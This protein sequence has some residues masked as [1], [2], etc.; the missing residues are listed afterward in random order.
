GLL[1]ERR[2]PTGGF[3]GSSVA[4][5]LRQTELD[6][7]ALLVREAM[8]NSVDARDDG[9]DE[10][11][12]DMHLRTL[13]AAQSNVLRGRVLRAALDSSALKEMLKLALPVESEGIQVLEVADWG[14]RGLG[15][16]VDPARATRLGERHDFVD[17]VFQIG[18]TRDRRARVGGGTFGFGKAAAFMMSAAST[19]LVHSAIR[20]RRGVE[21]RFIGIILGAE[22]SH[23]RQMYSGRHWLGKC[24]GGSRSIQP[25]VGSDARKVAEALG[26]PDRRKSP[27]TTLCIVAPRLDSVA[28]DSATDPGHGIDTTAR[29]V[30]ACR[31]ALAYYCWPLMIGVPGAPHPRVKARY[32]VDSDE[33]PG[34]FP[35]G[36]RF[37][38]S[39]R[40]QYEAL[41]GGSASKSVELESVSVQVNPGATELLGLH[42]AAA[43]RSTVDLVTGQLAL[44]K[45]LGDLPAF[46]TG[47]EHGPL[48]AEWPTHVA[49]MR[50][51]GTVVRYLPVVTSV[52]SSPSNALIGSFLVDAH[53]VAGQVFADAEPP[54]HDDWVP[55]NT[56]TK[57][58]A[59]VV[60]NTLRKVREAAMNRVR[61]PIVPPT[62]GDYLAGASVIGNSLGRVVALAPGGRPGGGG[63]S[64]GGAGSGG[65]G[66][67]GAKVTFT[68]LEVRDGCKIARFAV[69]GL[70]PRHSWVA[71]VA[72]VIDR[73]KAV[74]ELGGIPG[75]PVVSRWIDRDG[76]VLAT[77]ST[78]PPNAGRSSIDEECFVEVMFDADYAIRMSVAR[79]ELG[80]GGHP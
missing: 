35:S 12:F 16:P 75:A 69:R 1:S 23:R 47:R 77:G 14:T 74:T 33:V 55:E 21:E 27:G 67:E 58:G 45:Y 65:G 42:P 28:Q 7:P 30:A 3:S 19:V 8:Q 4:K 80:G 79:S 54:A 25:L 52:E 11:G 24:V 38:Q 20:T 2:S 70:K 61:P 63:G 18:K 40:A 39:L 50:R 22:H 9:V 73:G 32:F 36:H 13:S 56:G 60:R 49:L 17:F 43:R 29:F 76:T 48:Q 44:S 5:L 34:L 31:E 64:G 68:R 15:G 62:G 53:D 37:F 59:T 6:P 66:R 41:C 78:L 51:V 71:T 26:L 57:P 46:A 72:V 10:I